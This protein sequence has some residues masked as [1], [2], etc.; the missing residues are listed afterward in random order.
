M[1]FRSRRELADARAELAA[2][3]ESLDIAHAGRA[4]ELGQL[5]RRFEADWQRRE[6]A[7]RGAFEGARLAAPAAEPPPTGPR[8]YRAVG[9]H[10]VVVDGQRVKVA[11]GADLAEDFDLSLLPKGGYEVRA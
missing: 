3:R 2:A 5:R 11:H 7:M 1:L 6:A 4:E 8:R 10:V 9:N